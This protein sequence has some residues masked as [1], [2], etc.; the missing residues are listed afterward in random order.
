MDRLIGLAATGASP[1]ARRAALLAS[2]DEALTEQLVA[3][4]L[5]LREASALHGPIA[6]AASLPLAEVLASPF[7]LRAVA[8]GVEAGASTRHLELAHRPDWPELLDVAPEVRDPAHDGWE[9]GT[10]KSGKYQGFLADAPFAVYD[11]SHVSKWG[12]HELTHR[13]ASF[14]WRADATRWEHYLG[15]RLNELV[16]VVLWYGPEQ[17]MRLDE[18]AFDRAAAGRA[19]AARIEDARWLSEDETALPVRA[20]RAVTQL[21]EGLAHFERELAAIDEELAH[22]RRVRAPHP[23]LD[24]SSDA[25]AYVV[26]HYDRLRSPALTSVL[27]GALPESLR[28]SDIGAYRDF[29]EA[30]FDRLLFAPL[31]PDLARAEA[32]RS[33]RAL[34]DLLHRA[35]HLGEGM[36]AELEPLIDEARD[37]IEGSEEGRPVDVGA[38]RERLS[39]RLSEEEAALVLADGSGEGRALDRLADGIASVAPCTAEL[40]EPEALADF[41]GS[42][43]LW[44]RAPL[45]LRL[46][47]FL[48]GRALAELARFE[49]AIARATRDDQVERLCVPLEALPDVLESGVLIRNEAFQRLSFEHDVVGV[50]AALSAGEP[51]PPL[52][53]A[54][55]HLAGGR[56]LRPGLRAALPERGRRCLGAAGARGLRSGR[57][58]RD[59]RR[60]ARRDAGGL[61]RG[62]R[63]VD[64]RAA[65]GGRDRLERPGGLSVRQAAWM[66]PLRYERGGERRD[67]RAFLLEA[68]RTRRSGKIGG[69]FAARPPRPPI[70]A[71]NCPKSLTAE[72]A[73][74][75]R[76][77]SGRGREPS[78]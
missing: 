32:R 51:P 53:R 44:D 65:G 9:R 76:W 61:A 35:A 6:R 28:F 56:V 13:A 67:R 26:G 70:W 54:P 42:T 59:H 66:R 57:A 37:A 4:A 58:G 71:R 52:E 50:H 18:G 69:G 34:W 78:S 43:A 21:R 14:F 40:L 17:A 23:M 29:V 49:H 68:R 63:G 60:R 3:L 73:C 11:P 33:G 25:T 7:A 20:S 16:P 47:R 15:A 5:R 27:A 77:P 38:W 45:P 8:L 48:E 64:R 39:A 75:L 12:P 36:E 2:S 31:S 24:A 30:L 46:D 62:R 55:A 74:G 41:A 72:P 19:P 22:G 1:A 10:L